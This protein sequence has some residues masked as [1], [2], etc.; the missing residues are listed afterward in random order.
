MRIAARRFATCICFGGLTFGCSS[1]RTTA[2][3]ASAPPPPAAPA[4]LSAS[5]WGDLKPL[6]SV[7]ELMHDVI[8]PAAEPLFKAVSIVITKQHGM[9][10]NRPKTNDDWERIR[11]AGVTLAESVYLLK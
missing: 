8:S 9:V 2:P 10:E 3:A 5:L 4:S 1:P 6:V 11:M 7:K